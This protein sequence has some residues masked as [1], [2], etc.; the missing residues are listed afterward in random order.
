MAET[1]LPAFVIGGITPH[2]IDA[3][4]AAGAT[5]VA[6]GQAIAQADEPRQVAGLL[7]NK[8]K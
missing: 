2:T 6:V 3:A 7:R 1:A 4:V 8:L 5:R